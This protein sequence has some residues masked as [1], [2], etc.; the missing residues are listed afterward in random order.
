MPKELFDDPEVKTVT[1]DPVEEEKSLLDQVIFN[2]PE[3]DVIDRIVEQGSVGVVEGY[4]KMQQ[5]L[6]MAAAI[7]KLTKVITDTM[8]KNVMALQNTRLGFLTDNKDDGYPV[9]VV[10]P[11]CIEAVLR[12]FRLTG[13][14]FNIIAGNF[15][16]AKAGF[17]RLVKELDG[18]TNLIL[19]PGIPTIKEA[20]GGAFAP[21]RATWVF[22]GEKQEMERT[23]A[24]KV[25]DN[26]TVDNIQGRATRKILAAIYGQ[27]TG[28]EHA[29]PEG[30]VGEV[31]QPKKVQKSKTKVE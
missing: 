9:E 30:E 26:T 4:G 13:N 20:S 2:T 23:F 15:Y 29:V 8:M 3:L 6:V 19:Y 25:Y 16:G 10:K 12:G 24:V 18:L 31:I 17:A 1:T 21:F 5:A 7:I 11:I 28:S 22:N 27:L 14:E